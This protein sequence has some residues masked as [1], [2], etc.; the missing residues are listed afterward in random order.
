MRGGDSFR[1]LKVL[2]WVISQASYQPNSP[3]NKIMSTGNV[4]VTIPTDREIAMTRV[5]NASR[6]LVFDAYTKPD[7]LKQWLGAFDGWSLVVCEIDLKTGGTYRY[8]WRK[9]GLPEMGMRGVYREVVPPERIVATEVYDQ[10]WH[11]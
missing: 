9:Q 4:K 8:V 2:T 5:F 1:P 3:Y 10:P 7:L 6:K 11:E